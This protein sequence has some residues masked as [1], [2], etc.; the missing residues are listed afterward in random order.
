M[1]KYEVLSGSVIRNDKLYL[2][3]VSSAE[4]IERKLFQQD[5]DYEICASNISIQTIDGTITDG[6]RLTFVCESN[7]EGGLRNGLST[8]Y[9]DMIISDVLGT[10]ISDWY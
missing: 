7:K 1:E 9:V 6:I 2:T 5:V 10:Y 8:L 4:C 3:K